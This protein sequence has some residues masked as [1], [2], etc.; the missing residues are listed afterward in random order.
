MFTISKC[1]HIAWAYLYNIVLNIYIVYCC[2]HI[3]QVKRRKWNVQ[4]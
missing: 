4:I 2:V 3:F 1:T